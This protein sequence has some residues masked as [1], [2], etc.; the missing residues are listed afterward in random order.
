MIDLLDE[1]APALAQG[2][3][4][5]IAVV[6]STWSSAPRGVGAAMA[7]DANGRVY[8]SV[9]GGCVEGAVFEEAT[10]V[11]KE[12]RARRL[13]YGVSDGDAFAVGLTCGGTIELLVFHVGDAT[14]EVLS[15][16]R[17]AARNSVETGLVLALQE[18]V[19]VAAFDQAGLHGSFEDERLDQALASDALGFLRTGRSAVL[20]LGAHG[21]RRP[22]ESEFLVLSFPA[23][24]RMFVFG[25]IDFARAVAD[26][27]VFLGFHTIVCD[28]RPT[29]AT[30]A[31]FPGAHEVVVEWPH[32]YLTT[33]DVSEH[34]AICVL[35]HDPKFDVPLL[36]EALRT[37]AGYIGVMGSRRTHERR[38]EELKAAGVPDADLARLHAPIGLDLGGRTPE[39]TAVSI[40]AEIIKER[41]QGSGSPLSDIHGPIHR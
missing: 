18:Q 31:R 41:W 14:A 28:A 15:A 29:F 4:F 16:V 10:A 17:A 22:D 38:L 26:M 27:G 40:A 2:Q 32:R 36:V 20:H 33:V 23:P 3:R 39:E 12:G 11:L 8:G 6:T 7:V 1:I 24:P 19:R 21:E 5:A 25:A 37:P 9:S 13:R 35:T 34:D 30:S